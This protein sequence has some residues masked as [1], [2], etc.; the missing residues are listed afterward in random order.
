MPYEDR[1]SKQKPHWYLKASRKPQQMNTQNKAIGCGCGSFFKRWPYDYTDKEFNL[2]QG[3][4]DWIQ[5]ID[6]LLVD[7]QH[8]KQDDNN[9]VLPTD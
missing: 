2:P 3:H 8:C 5:T 4:E 1:H 6:L 9:S 7:R